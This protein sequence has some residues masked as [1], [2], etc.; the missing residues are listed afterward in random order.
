M[1][2]E[3]QSVVGIAIAALGGAAVGLERE[4]SGHAGGPEAHFAG[5]RTF[6]LLGGLAGVA[7]WLWSL[8][9]RPL[10]IVLLASAAA[11]VVAAYVAAS[12][13]VIDGTTEVA[14]LVVLSA[15]ILAGTGYLVLASAITAITTLLLVEKSRLHAMIARIDDAGLRAGV[16]FAVMA[17]VILPLL[18]EGPYGPLGGVRPRQLW[19]FVLLFSGLN[20]IGYVARRVIDTEHG[21]SVAGLLGGFVS[22]TAVAFTFSR[23]SRQD[24]NFTFP[25]SVGVV[26]AC[27]V[28]TLRVLVATA[29]LRPALALALIPYLAAPFLVGAIIVLVGFKR[30]EEKASVQ[31]PSNPLQVMSALQMAALFQVVL[32]AV[33]A[34]RAHWGEAGVLF[35]GAVLGLTDVDVLT[36]SM[37]KSAEGQITIPVAAQAIAIGILS[38]TIMKLLLGVAIGKGR[39]RILMPAWLA[40]MAIAS[41]ASI[42][43]LR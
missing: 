32:F 33:Y 21:Y 29:V 18:P 20:F 26:A 30:R 10:A 8:G 4:W 17:V 13:R 25:L 23:L 2:L 1:F 31:S 7:G 41:A 16:R 11:L 14:A 15:G 38:N 43:A 27:S 40:L 42:A 22:S 34:V 6:T 35:S 36:I 28:M 9:F 24:H 19:L 12:R 3:Q 5:I 39:F 37:A